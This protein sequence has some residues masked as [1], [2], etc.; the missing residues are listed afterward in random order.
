MPD[1]SLSDLGMLELRQGLLEERSAPELLHELASGEEIDAV[2]R[3]QLSG[4][5]RD[6]D[7]PSHLHFFLS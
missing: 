3:A 7:A 1:G 5:Q 2:F 4:H 6:H